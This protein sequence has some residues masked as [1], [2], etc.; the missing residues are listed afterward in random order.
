MYNI[1]KILQFCSP[2]LCVF[3]ERKT[4]HIH[5]KFIHD[6]Y[7]TFVFTHN[8]VC[9]L[10]FFLLM[11]QST[12]LSSNIC[13]YK[14]AHNSQCLRKFRKHSNIFQTIHLKWKVKVSENYF[15]FVNHTG[16]TLYI[17]N[18]MY[19]RNIKFVYKLDIIFESTFV[20]LRG[21]VRLVTFGKCI[22]AFSWLLALNNSSSNIVFCAMFLKNWIK[23]W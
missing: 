16:I 19:I 3:V 6:K 4:K 14:Q 10:S 23:N 20:S 1:V 5:S 12:S 22:V 2:A 7:Y 17:I 8:P 21:I 18:Y 9:W 15:K 13:F 11:R